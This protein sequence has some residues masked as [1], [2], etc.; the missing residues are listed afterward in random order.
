MKRNI[1]KYWFFIMSVG[2][3]FTACQDEYELGEVLPVESLQY[4]ITQNPDDPNMVIL[5]SLTPNVTPLWTTPMGPSTRVKDTVL[6]PFSGVY[7]FVYGVE[8]AGGF[9]S[10]DTVE[11]NI[12]TQNL[13]Y[14]DHP[15][16]DLLTGGG[17][18]F[19][20]TWELDLNAEGISK[21]FVGPQYF[22]GTDNGWL[23]ECL[24]EGG[25][26]W[27][28]EADWPG[29]Q[30]I[31]DVGDY[32]E[33]TFSLEGGAFLTVN[34]SMIPA[35]GTE[36]GTYFLDVDNYSMTF[37]NASPLHSPNT[38]ACVPNWYAVR[39]FSI[40][41]DYMQLGFKRDASCDG[42]LWLVFNYIS[43]EYSDNWVPDDAPDPEPPY[44]GDANSDLTT[45]VSTT[46]T[47]K[48][49]L[50]YPYNWHDLAGTP[51]ND[52]ATYGSDPEGFAFTTWTP[53]YDETVFS[54]ISVELTK[55]GESDGTYV[56]QTE[57]GEVTGDYTVNAK[58]EIDFGQP[59]T[60]FSGVG[61]WLGFSTTA[62]NT[63]RIIAAENDA[64]GNVTG[65]WLG[66][67]A[68]DK[69]EYFSLHLKSVANSGG[70]PSGTGVAFDNTKLAFGDLEGNGNLRL[71][72]YNDFGSTKADPPLDPTAVVFNNRIE[73]TFTLQGITLT[74]GAAGSYN[75]AVGLADGDWSAQYWG[76]GPGEVAVTGDGTYTVYAE[77]GSIY[78]TALVFVVDIKGMAAEI[79]DLGAVTVTI[80]SIVMY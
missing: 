56:I 14:V 7:Q 73:I 43:K 50:D 2:L 33:M 34:H 46:K 75:T 17:V 8:S 54:S 58:N 61:G 59:I 19:S 31:A 10:A 13:S 6:L 44:N 26:C 78:E 1:L 52:V 68:V 35:R 18:G 63:L 74:G 69:D 24:V 20:K 76:D 53:P 37:N 70:Q 47:W 5:E 9:V 57:T 41:K 27:S 60:F 3:L 40:A 65:I 51:L 48:V 55:V 28:W 66:Q 80:D 36:S 38:E 21:Y 25:N 49:D 67:K 62:E 11:L 23:G 22:Y 72:L 42:E 77:P 12:T 64:F 15:L 30:W 16:W 4:E 79:A 45:N 71:E 32:G 39:V 29:N